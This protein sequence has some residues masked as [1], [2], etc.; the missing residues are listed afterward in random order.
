[1]WKGGRSDVEVGCGWVVWRRG[2][3]WV[4]VGLWMCFEVGR[5]WRERGGWVSDV[6]K[7]VWMESGVG[8][9]GC[10]E[11]DVSDRIFR[12]FYLFSFI[13]F[14]FFF[15]LIFLLIFFLNILLFFFLPL[16]LSSLPSQ[17]PLSTLS[18]TVPSFPSLPT[19]FP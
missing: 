17:S 7:A 15:P 12:L 19:P 18:H 1:M 10:L 6:E 16:L 3:K 4:W 14:S 8:G 13:S 9:C 11:G 5:M 2:W